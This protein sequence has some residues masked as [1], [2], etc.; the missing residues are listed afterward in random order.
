MEFLLHNVDRVRTWLYAKPV[1]PEQRQ[2][3]LNITKPEDQGLI[4][5]LMDEP[6]NLTLKDKE[7]MATILSDNHR[8]LFQ[9][10]NQK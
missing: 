3:V 10:K 8:K 6:W 2:L 9:P 1:S 4:I 5:K 7:K